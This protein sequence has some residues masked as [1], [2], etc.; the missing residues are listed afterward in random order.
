MGCGASQP[1]YTQAKFDPVSFRT[2]DSNPYYDMKE[3]KTLLG[4]G[5]YGEV[6][7]C[8]ETGVTGGQGRVVALKLMDKNSEMVSGGLE[9]LAIEVKVHKSLEHPNIIRMFNS[10]ETLSHVAISMEI[11]T[12][13]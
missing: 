11:C 5:S 3:W 4:E 8:V 6:Y 10:H 13:R 7:E 2:G 1:V 9:L 12:V